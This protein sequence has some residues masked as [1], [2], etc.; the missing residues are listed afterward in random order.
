MLEGNVMWL[1]GKRKAIRFV[2]HSRTMVQMMHVE[3]GVEGMYLA[4]SSD[5]AIVWYRVMSLLY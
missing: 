4:E 2:D 5:N 3:G 1:S